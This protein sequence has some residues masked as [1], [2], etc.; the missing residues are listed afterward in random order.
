MNVSINP[1]WER[2]E[3]LHLKTQFKKEINTLLTQS[4]FSLDLLKPLTMAVS[5]GWTQANQATSS[6]LPCSK[7]TYSSSQS[8]KSPVANIYYELVMHITLW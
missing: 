5:F 7:P 3:D 2:L 4:T 8:V 1:G 6:P